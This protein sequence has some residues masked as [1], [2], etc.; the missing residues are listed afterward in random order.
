MS[1]VRSRR[2]MFVFAIAA[3]LLMGLSLVID[4]RWLEVVLTGLA[5]VCGVL[6]LMVLTNRQHD[7][8]GPSGQH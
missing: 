1:V 8:N 4:E 2:N 3:L 5:T 7:P 6:F